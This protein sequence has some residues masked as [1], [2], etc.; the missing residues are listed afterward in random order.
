M[1]FIA[2]FAGRRIA[3]SRRWH[4]RHRG[5]SRWASRLALAPRGAEFLSMEDSKAGIVGADGRDGRERDG[6][7]AR[8]GFSPH[9]ATGPCATLHGG[10]TP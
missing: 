6:P 1:V 4:R 5:R 3:P 10:H 7:P 2:C 9:P 8:S